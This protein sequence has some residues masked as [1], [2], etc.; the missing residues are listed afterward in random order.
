MPAIN[1]FT[2]QSGQAPASS[3]FSGQAQRSQAQ[4][5]KNLISNVGSWGYGALAA[6]NK[7][8]T[9]EWMGGP[10]HQQQL[11]SA[12]Q[13][14]QALN[15]GGNPASYAPP[16]WLSKL[17]QAPGPY[18]TGVDQFG[19]VVPDLADETRSMNAALG[20]PALPPL[21]SIADFSFMRYG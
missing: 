17:T 11:Q 6:P 4:L 8:P 10:S 5:P 9:P 12:Y 3:A 1:P 15:P 7:N 16:N 14:W 20:V 18:S 19:N 13:N 2:K 21:P